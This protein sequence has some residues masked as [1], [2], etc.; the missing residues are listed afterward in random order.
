MRQEPPAPPQT[1]EA[2]AAGARLLARM[3]REVGLAAIAIEL[4]LLEEDL[5]EEMEDAIE[6]GA[7]LLAEFSLALA[8]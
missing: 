3:H 8:S 6:R 7:R 5:G 4:N 2:P 1:F